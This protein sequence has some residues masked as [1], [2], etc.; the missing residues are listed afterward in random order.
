MRRIDVD[1]H[2]VMFIAI[3]RRDNAG[4]PAI[5]VTDQTR[6]CMNCNTSILDEIRLL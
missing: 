1:D 2:L 5:E 3:F 4:H 6:L